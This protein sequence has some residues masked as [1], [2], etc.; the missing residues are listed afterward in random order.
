V[1]IDPQTLTEV[2]DYYGTLLEFNQRFLR[3]PGIQVAVYA[4]DRIVFS[5]GL[6]PGRG[7]Q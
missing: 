3:V 1:A 4:D 5:A 7:G 2:V 6:R